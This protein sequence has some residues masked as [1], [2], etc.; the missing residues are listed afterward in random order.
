MKIN[1]TIGIPVWLDNI[2]TWPVMWYRRRKFGYDF[3]RIYLGEDE[4]TILDQQ[5]YYRLGNLKWSVIG[6][7]KHIYAARL[8]RK[9]EYGRIKSVY[10]H[11]EIMNAP[12]GLLVDHENGNGLDNRRANLRLATHSQNSC[13]RQIDKTKSLSHFR[14]ARLDKRNGRWFTAIRINGKRLWFGH[15][16]SEIEAAKAYDRAAIKYHGEFA[17]L[18]FPQDKAG[19]C[20]PK[21]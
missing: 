9:T 5:D 8:I 10:L 17:R 21:L 15:F 13:N 1:L 12:A 18:N 16:D 20:P 11:R 3:R 19:A 6:Y 14:G 2:C 7:D 4:W